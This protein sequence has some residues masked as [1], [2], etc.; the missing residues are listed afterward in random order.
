MLWV[1]ILKPGL[2]GRCPTTNDLVRVDYACLLARSG[3]LVDSSR[4]GWQR[5][6]PPSPLAVVLGSKQVVDGMDHGLRRLTLGALARIHC[7]AA[8]GYG[9]SGIHGTV[10]PDADLVF[11]VELLQINERS[12][13]PLHTIELR[14]LLMMP[15]G[16]QGAGSS[17][18][19]SVSM[20]SSA[21]IASEQLAVQ[22][23]RQ[24][25]AMHAAL[26]AA[27]AE[28][29]QQQLLE[30][31]TRT[32]MQ[33]SR[34]R[35][36]AECESSEP[37][38]SCSS[39]CESDL[40]ATHEACSST[41]ERMTTLAEGAGSVSFWPAVHRLRPPVCVHFA[42]TDHFFS[43]MRRLGAHAWRRA[44][45]GVEEDGARTLLPGSLPIRRAA[46]HTAW[47]SRTPVVLTGER[48]A[49]PCFRWGWR[50]WRSRHGNDLIT[51]S[52]RAPVFDS[53]VWEHSVNAEMSL[54]EYIDYARNAH[55]QPE[56]AQMQT[57]L[58]YA[59][60]TRRPPSCA[61]AARLIVHKSS[62]TTTRSRSPARGLTFAHWLT[63]L[64]NL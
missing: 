4:A 62:Q 41:L 52:Q 6:R 21:V 57:P 38:R 18:S 24:A 58:L 61:P 39:E 53:D 28:I 54:R 12:H 42:E 7:P 2:D 51:A 3:R 16:G 33:H 17:R 64:G 40:E 31:R 37:L 43:L 8:L 55:R 1:E 60:G 56:E 34:E 14:H 22:D 19:G 49:W 11:E 27:K 5:S 50:Y 59:N 63:R 26:D 25:S 20:A 29:R 10:P 15:V 32:Q 13:R 46:Y 45:E 47:D 36:E 44:L 30:A 48:R 9:S 35:H 23:M